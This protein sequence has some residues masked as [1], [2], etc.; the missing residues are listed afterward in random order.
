MSSLAR[1]LNLSMRTCPPRS[2]LLRRPVAYPTASQV[3]VT[4]N[5]R[6]PT[7]HFPNLHPQRRLRALEQSALT[8]LSFPE[9]RITS[10]STTACGHQV[11]TM[12]PPVTSIMT[13]YQ[14]T[15]A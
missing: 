12:D 2:G 1:H 4:L 15:H 7:A 9:I 10:L 13:T 3:R 6:T 8:T 11:L 5:G 14:L